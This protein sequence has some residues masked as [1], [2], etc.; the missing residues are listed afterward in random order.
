MPTYTPIPPRLNVSKNVQVTHSTSVHHARSESVVSIN[1]WN[2][3]NI[4]AASKR[5]RNLYTY[6]FII[7]AAVSFDGGKSWDPSPYRCT[8]TGESTPECP[9][10][11]LPGTITD[12]CTCLWGRIG[13]ALIQPTRLETQ[14]LGLAY[15]ST[16]PRMRAEP[17]E[18]PS[19]SVRT[20]TTINSGQPVIS[21]TAV[22]ITATCM[23][24]GGL[25]APAFRTHQHP[26]TAWKGPGNR[27]SRTEHPW[28]Q[29]VFG[30][31]ISGWA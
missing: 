21:P 26:G 15:G 13:K 9:T 14:R 18:P 3:G 27:T 25:D 5:F 20:E 31:E 29:K 4:V 8:G 28:I 11:R 1:P 22:R 23:L 12:G 24:R 16:Y 17:G 19:R 10:P 6:D 2:S 30:P 7:E